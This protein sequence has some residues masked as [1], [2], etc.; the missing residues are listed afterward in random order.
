MKN[1]PSL[2]FTI[3]LIFTALAAGSI[4]A[5]AA[6]L[7]FGFH[8]QDQAGSPDAVIIGGFLAGITI[9]GLITWTWLLFD[10]NIAKPIERLAGHLRTR[11]HSSVTMPI[12]PGPSRYLGD[13]A[14]AAQDLA[15]TLHD[16]RQSLA[17]ST[18]RET[19]GLAYEKAL[20][21]TL[22]TDISAGVLM[23]SASHQLVFYNGRAAS[24][25][26]GLDADATPGLNRSLFDY[27]H[28]PP[29][30]A[31]YARLQSTGDA[32]AASDILCATQT[33][34]TTLLARMRLLPVHEQGA[35]PGYMMTL[36]N[37]AAFSFESGD[38]PLVSSDPHSLW[39]I[40][41]SDLA[42]ALQAQLNATGFG[43]RYSAP[44]IIL[45][46]NGFQVVALLDALAR[47]VAAR[48]SDLSLDISPEGSGASISLN[49]RGLPLPQHEVEQLLSS[50][51][52]TYPATIPIQAV[53]DGHAAS[54][55]S[56]VQPPDRASLSVTISEARL[57]QPRAPAISQGLVYDFELL[58]KTPKTE[59]SSSHIEDLTYVVFDTETTG[60]RPDQGDEI[61]QI[62]A[63]R[64]VNGRRVHKEVFN[65]LV[66]PRRAIPTSSTNVHG[67]T[68]Y[69][70][71]S[72]PTI[73][74]V[75]RKFHQFIK[76]AVLVAHNAP[77][78]MAF[79]R[80]YEQTMGCQFDNP[81]LDTVLLSALVFGQSD[82]HSLDSLSHR[83]GITITEEARHTAIG[84]ASATAD[85][86]LKLIPALKARGL[87]TFG[88]VLAEVRKHSRLLK[89]LNG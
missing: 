26:G 76:G 88:D 69:M 63:V 47:H 82:S 17:A 9:V 74:E 75:G 19:A 52:A 33:T 28:P 53:L 55:E 85:V 84:D 7:Y 65:T 6:G 25:I 29:V 13:L 58:L 41:A 50:D 37:N 79:L 67:I 81:V 31:G 64:I 38:D 36:H 16:T 68:D 44:H 54:L 5:L 86:F 89:D 4:V 42:G 83:L 8:K 87:E 48:G 46:C 15:Q 57:A 18:A 59:L 73:E 11:T 62:A 20:L 24:L 22:L 77:F 21:E 60:L 35:T 71:A 43:L 56:G 45:R 39:M 61:V 40:H 49:W 3:F 80:R 14:T 34:G 1:R 27:L 51:L 10:D 30:L 70:V 12:D 72:A 78:D 66:N 2:R 23:C 32:D